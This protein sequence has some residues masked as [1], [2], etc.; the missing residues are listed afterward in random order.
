MSYHGGAASEHLRFRNNRP[1]VVDARGAS[2][3]T[4]RWSTTYLGPAG[5][6]NDGGG[7]GAVRGARCFVL[8]MHTMA[9]VDGRRKKEGFTE[10]CLR[11]A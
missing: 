6:R 3:Y 8:R 10:T 7:G 11:K 9:D 1:P 2:C 4:V 5:S